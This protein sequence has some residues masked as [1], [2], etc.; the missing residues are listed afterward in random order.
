MFSRFIRPSRAVITATAAVALVVAGAS[1][2]SATLPQ[3]MGA[4]GLWQAL[5]KLQTTAS[6]MHTAA[7]P[8]DEHGGAL[9]LLSRRDGARVSYLTLNRGESGDNAIGPQLFEG[10][11]MIRTEELLISGRYY[12]LDNQ[13]FTTVLDYGFSKRIEEAFEK[14]GR[15]AVM[16]DVVR[17]IRMDRPYILLSRFQGN[18]RDGHGNHQ[19]AGL[20]TTLAFKAA[21]DPNMY[22]EQIKEGLRPWQPHKVYIGGVR[23][24]E[25]WNVKI[26]AG[27][28]SP[29]IGD[30]YSNFARKGLSFQRS[31]TSGRYNPQSGPQ[32]GY[33]TRV[34]SVIGGAVKEESIFDGI[35]T[36]VPGLFK[37]LR[38][39][40]PAGAAPLL[41]AIDAAVKKAFAAFSVT[42]PSA[43]VPALAEGLSAT[44]AALATLGSDPDAAF[45]LKAKE[46]QF[47]EAINVALGIDLWA[48]AQAAGLPEPTGPMA[49]FAPPPAMAAPVPGQTFEIR[50]RATNRGNVQITPVE[51]G[52]ETDKGWNVQKGQAEMAPLAYNASASQ[53]FTVT[54]AADV[55]LSTRAYFSRASIQDTKYTLSDPSQFGRPVSMP[56]AIAVFKYTVN[57]VNVAARTTVTRREPKLPYGDVHRELRVVPALGVSVSPGSAIIP[58]SA[59]TKQVHLT[60]DLLNNNEGAIN[61]QLAL[62]LPATWTSQPA[63]QPFAFQRAGERAT[64]T[65]TVNVPAL[66]NKAY[67]IEAVATANGRQY[68]EGYETIDHRDLEVRYLYRAS[69]VDVNGLDVKVVPS[70]HVGYV[71]GVGDQ[72]PTGI[73]QLGYKVSLLTEADLATG[74]LSQYDAIMTGTRAY[75]VRED[76][77]TYNQRLLDYVKEG[78]N[79]VVLYNTQE[80]IPA[81]FAPFPGDH[82]QR[83]EEVSEEDSPVTILAPD[84]QA[85]NWPNKITLADFNN[86]VEQRGSKFWAGW[87]PAYTAMIETYDKGQAPQKGGW[88]Q[89]KHGKGTYTYFAY[90]FHRQL[91]YGV[92]GAY[93]LLANVLALGKPTTTAVR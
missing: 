14:W 89:A 41:A 48:S 84:M 32:P 93:R 24:N 43:T 17:L 73:Q 71:M 29:W 8:D 63:T 11:G 36:T 88:L 53:R 90:A 38:K 25:A 58:V 28:F 68:K 76:L 35:D 15:D 10:L 7:H 61:G 20:I 54:L 55:P 34:D 5:L 31:Q 13:Y 82:G 77:K 60:V 56:P 70:L 16:R 78:G 19:T 30:S 42:N 49:G 27:E 59:A 64:Y 69:K 22:P 83:A 86:W 66:E 6:V 46:E 51:I 87:D 12:G 26:D 39:P 65:F 91:P 80:L 23:E 75:A 81:K 18:Q 40:E 9:A 85:L 67:T 21:G 79:L 3:D 74:N 47:Q 37:A 52:L 92:P 2:R 4:D 45:V 1:L 57:G 72:V 50:T 62:T 33:Y 44:R